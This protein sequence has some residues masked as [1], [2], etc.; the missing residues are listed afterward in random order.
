VTFGAMGSD[1][2][3]GRLAVAEAPAWTD[4][5]VDA[6]L[7][8]RRRPGANDPLRFRRLLMT[9]DRPIARGAFFRRR[10]VRV[11]CVRRRLRGLLQDQDG[12]KATRA[13][14][15]GSS[16]FE[17]HGAPVGYRLTTVC[18]T[19]NPNTRKYSSR[20]SPAARTLGTRAVKSILFTSFGASR[21]SS[22]VS[23]GA[24]DKATLRRTPPPVISTKPVL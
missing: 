24:D 16:S 21:N 17:S 4:D 20:V 11:P 14:H 3:R 9:S 6:D 7:P 1:G 23:D 12:W 19:F 2:P 10:P 22:S 5:L 8:T 13:D 15:N 18:D